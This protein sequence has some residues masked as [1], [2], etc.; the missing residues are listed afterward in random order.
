MYFQVDITCFIYLQAF[1]DEEFKSALKMEV[2]HY[3]FKKSL[4]DIVVSTYR[5]TEYEKCKITY[6][7]YEW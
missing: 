6:C 7:R 1:N 3:N 2:D 4:F 5:A